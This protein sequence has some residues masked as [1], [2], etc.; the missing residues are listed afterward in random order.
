MRSVIRIRRCRRR[1]LAALEWDGLF[2]HHRA[3]I[4]RTYR[5]QRAGRQLMLVADVDGVPRAQA[6]IDLRAARDRTAG[7]IWALRI[8]PSIQQRGLG[9]RLLQAA[10]AELRARGFRAAEL[11]VEPANARARRLYAR[12][13]YVEV[14]RTAS[15]YDYTTPEGVYCRHELRLIE[16]RKELHAERSPVIRWTVGNV[17]E[18]GFEALRLSVWGAYRLF[19]SSA[20]F[21]ICLNS[22]PLARAQQ[23][24]GPLPAHVSW[25]C[26]TRDEVA[27]FIL[28]HLD[29]QFAEGVGWKFAPF[30]LSPNRAE[31]ALD[32]DCI[33]WRMPEAVGRWL[34]G[35]DEAPVIAEDVLACFGQFTPLCTSA[36]RNSGL[37]ALPQGYDLEGRMRT[38]LSR[39]PV[40]MRSETDEQGLQ[41]AAVSLDG[42]PRIVTIDEVSICSPFPPHLPHLGRCGAHFVGLNAHALPWSLQGRPAVAHLA[43]HWRRHRREV[44]ARVGVEVSHDA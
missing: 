32:N 1:D 8:H 4:E 20:D 6:W 13:G 27:P 12:A 29:D 11:A 35:D 43:D 28:P 22:V 34:N 30:R 2:T 14:G 15:S 38:A 23:L 16:M 31:L 21:V 42:E 7:V 5:E 33:L 18:F 3:I 36:P 39:L 41:V 26:V 10:E 37:R 9:A 44:A 17:S 24:T 19:G 25:R 40:V